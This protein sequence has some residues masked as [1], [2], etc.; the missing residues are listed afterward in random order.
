MQAF[1]GRLLFP[2]GVV[3]PVDRPALGKVGDALVT[4]GPDLDS[5]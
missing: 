4:L 1:F 5:K 2:E 3:T